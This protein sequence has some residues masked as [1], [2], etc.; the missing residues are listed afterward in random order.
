M[1]TYKTKY[2]F[3]KKIDNTLLL[4]RLINQLE[5][6]SKRVWIWTLFEI[7]NSKIIW[8]LTISTMIAIKAIN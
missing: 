1:R 6:K 3:K 8:I 7:N 4:D 5:K 2:F